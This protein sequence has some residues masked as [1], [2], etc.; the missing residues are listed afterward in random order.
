MPL[1]NKG[2]A[3]GLKTPVVLDIG[4]A[5]TKLGFADEAEPRAIIPTTIEQVGGP[6]CYIFGRNNTALLGH[7]IGSDFEKSIKL[8]LEKI[9]FKYLQVNPNNQRV[10][11]CES[12][13]NPTKVRE[14]IAKVLF[15]KFDVPSVLFAPCHLLA[16]FTV[17]TSTALVL[18]CGHTESVV[19]PV[20]E[21]TP[22]LWAWQSAP[23]GGATIQD[24]IMHEIKEKGKIK[25][26]NENLL[27]VASRLCETVLEDI[28]VKACLV[29]EYHRA[30][31]IQAA[32][33]LE[34]EKE[35]EATSLTDI[36]RPP[37][38]IYPIDGRSRL[39]IPGPIREEAAEVLFEQDNEKMSLATLLLDSLCQCPIDARKALARNVLVTGGTS[40]LPGFKHRLLFEMKEIIKEEQRYEKL[41]E[42]EFRVHQPPTKANLVAWLGASI[43]ASLDT[44][45]KRSITKEYFTQH[46]GRL[47]DWCVLDIKSPDKMP[48]RPNTLPTGKKFPT[49]HVPSRKSTTTAHLDTHSKPSK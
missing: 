28:K 33:T 22:L 7:D 14:T 44:F 13:L 46:N 38:M 25:S 24:A 17:A 40:L 42:C 16:C 12:L 3:F 43:F 27:P 48:E 34:L 6:V 9:Y 23:L 21:G 8:F 19:I 35:K 41:S 18:D 26:E 20:V 31:Q 32:K 49:S 45:E 39:F 2:Y 47:P 1:F 5:Y 37:D 30:K 10:I 29:T 11:L 36:Q 4:E 15:T